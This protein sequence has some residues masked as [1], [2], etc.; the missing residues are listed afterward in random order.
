M[1]R[2]R[3]LYIDPPWYYYGGYNRRRIKIRPP[4][5]TMKFEELAS[6][7]IREIADNNCALFM[8]ATGP[9]MNQAI[10]LIERWGF[11]F[12]TVAFVWIKTT[13]K[14]NTIRYTPAYWTMA[15]AEYLLFAKKGRPKRNQANVKQ[16]LF[17]PLGKLHSAKPPIVRD[18]IVDLVKDGPRLE[19][20]ARTKAPGWD[21]IGNEIDG[22]DIRIAL[23]NIINQVQAA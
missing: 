4:Y 12:T 13:S 5:P 18:R 20:F 7:P 11:H 1:K 10:H 9:Q 14:A 17:A 8:W 6:L 23:R 22:L 19:V 2:Y 21:A 3:V 15:N 16:I